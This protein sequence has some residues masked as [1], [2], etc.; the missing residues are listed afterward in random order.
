MKIDNKNTVKNLVSDSLTRAISYTQFRKLVDELASIGSNS[1]AEKK[2]SL[3]KYTQ[4]NSRR[5]KRWDKTF[6]ISE[7]ETE[8][9]KTW[10][11]PVI[12]L[13]LTESWCGDAAPTM[14]VMDKIAALNKNIEYKVL[15]RDENLELMDHFLTDGTR[16]IPK[17]IMLDADSLEVLGDWG[18][19]P[20]NANQMA[21]EYKRNY[22][23]LSPEFK[24]D[25]QLW[26]NSDKGENTLTDL[27][28]LLALKDVSNGTLLRS[29]GSRVKAGLKGI[30]NRIIHETSI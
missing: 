7:Q 4:L 18:P 24:Q 25:L 20:S 10:E 26:Y 5:L 15:F 11:R 22:G 6:R 29:S 17:L 1:G 28:D 8:N 9:I 30:S 27:L 14:P 23:K 12:W 3:I 16:S 21:L 2:E 13:V 19:R